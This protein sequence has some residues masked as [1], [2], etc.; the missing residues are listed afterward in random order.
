MFFSQKAAEVGGE[1]PINDIRLTPR[2]LD[3]AAVEKIAISAGI[4]RSKQTTIL[5]AENGNDA[6]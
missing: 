3:S 5:Q 4:P 1:A 6:C 2:E